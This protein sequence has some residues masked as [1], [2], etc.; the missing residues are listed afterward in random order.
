M[1][2]FII[3]EEERKR[4]LGI[5]EQRTSRHYLM[6]E[7]ME[8][9]MD[10]EIIEQYDN[11][12]YSDIM[13][14]IHNSNS[15]HEETIDV[16]NSIVDEMSSSKRM[17]RNVEKRFR[18][19][20]NEQSP[21]APGMAPKTTTPP[22]VNPTNKSSIKYTGEFKNEVSDEFKKKEFERFIKSQS[23][24]LQ[25][26]LLNFVPISNKVARMNDPNL[27]TGYSRM[28]IHKEDVPKDIKTNP[29]YSNLKLD[30]NGGIEQV[31]VK[32][33]CK[34][35]YEKLVYIMS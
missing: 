30:E 7:P 4:I 6:E 5:H 34:K 35:E 10:E 28:F 3:T 17:R 23:G 15:S 19:E 24:G 21:Y 25:G 18:D 31:D 27:H 16:L 29:C 20:M 11:S 13:D 33:S 22:G 32:I 9:E 8:P 12:L 26:W 2:Q 14:L 1:K